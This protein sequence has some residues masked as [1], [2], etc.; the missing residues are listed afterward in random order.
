MKGVILAGGTGSRLMPSTKVTNKHLLPVYDRP[1]IYYPLDTLGKAGIDD[2]LI[3]SGQGHA[4]DFLELLGDGS[5]IPTERKGREL[6]FNFDGEI[7]YKIQKEPLGIAHALSLAD[8]FIEP[9]EK[10]VVILGDNIY[11]GDPSDQIKSFEE[12]DFE[13][14]VFL[15]EV[16]DPQRFGNPRVEGDRITH[17]EEKP[18]EPHSEYA[19]TGL[20]GFY[21]DEENSLFKHIETLEPSDRGEYEI[22]DILRWYQERATMT[23]EEMDMFWTDAGKPGAL[24]EASNFMKRKFEREE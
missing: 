17:I 18:D 1:M 11:G 7:T 14:Q 15:K 8:D 9:G 22:T 23:F 21:N 16:E 19:I 12:S 6:E 3:I 10:F 13:A 4:G 24:L 2:V 20:Y 5:D